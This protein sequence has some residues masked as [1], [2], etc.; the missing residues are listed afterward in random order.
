MRVH[1][2]QCKL[3]VHQDSSHVMALFVYPVF[4]GYKLGLLMMKC[5]NIDTKK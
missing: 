4:F 2:A 5:Y 3:V 1:I